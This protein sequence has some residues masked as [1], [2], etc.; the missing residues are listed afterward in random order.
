M[1]KHEIQCC[2]CT[3]GNVQNWTTEK[4]EVLVF[5]IIRK[6][7]LLRKDHSHEKFKKVANYKA[8]IKYISFIYQQNIG[9]TVREKK[10]SVFCDEE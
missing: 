7:K 10:T 9:E 1:R 8:M 2:A 3:Q 4:L 6:D 5:I